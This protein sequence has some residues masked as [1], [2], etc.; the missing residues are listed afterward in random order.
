MSPSQ[1]WYATAKD[2]CGAL[3]K[4]I[5]H[6]ATRHC[7]RCTHTWD[8]ESVASAPLVSGRMA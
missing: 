3:D 8:Y 6:T 1:T 7:I 4:A 2:D 5:L